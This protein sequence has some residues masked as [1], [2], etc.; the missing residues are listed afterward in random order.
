MLIHAYPGKVFIPHNGVFDTC[1]FWKTL[2]IRS[3]NILSHIPYHYGCD[4]QLK[5]ISITSKDSF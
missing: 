5:T 1:E 4:Y 2:N 3:K